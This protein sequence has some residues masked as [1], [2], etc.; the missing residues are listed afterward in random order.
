MLVSMLARIEPSIAGE[1]MLDSMRGT[2][3]TALQVLSRTVVFGV[4][5]PYRGIALE[6]PDL[7]LE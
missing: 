1:P 7:V 3:G 6:Y 5:I 4:E 2:H